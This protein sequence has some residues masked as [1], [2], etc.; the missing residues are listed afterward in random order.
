MIVNKE[1]A[2][3]KGCDNKDKW[4][5]PQFIF[6]VLNEEFSFTLD[7]CCDV[8]TAKCK[9]F[10]TEK[11]DGLIQSWKNEIVFVNPPYSRGNIDKWMKKCYEE[12][13][14]GTK[15]I[16][17]IPVSSSS[18]WWHKYV[19][20]KSEIRFYKGRIKFVGAPFTAPFSSCLAIYN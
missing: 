18:N 3:S 17:L 8:N 14:N 15:I 6:N 19:W 5:T 20:N 12:S 16:A 7:P 11:E 4:E 2:T 1:L 9:N 13:L 10:F